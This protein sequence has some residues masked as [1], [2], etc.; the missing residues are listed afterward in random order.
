MTSLEIC[1]VSRLL[2]L[3]SP[4]VH[5]HQARKLRDAEHSSVRYIAYVAAAEKKGRHVMLTKACRPSMFFT[6]TMLLVLLCE[7]GAVDQAGVTS[8]R[9]PDVRNDSAAAT[10][11][12][13]LQQFPRAFWI[14]AHLPAGI[15][16]TS[17]LDFFW[18]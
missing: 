13:C 12:R 10:R 8:V 2:Q 17:L 16:R 1:S 5:V 18:Y 14:F 11:F 15:C 7:D 3:K 9:Y 6:M 4:R